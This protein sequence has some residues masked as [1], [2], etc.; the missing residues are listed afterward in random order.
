MEDFN[1]KQILAYK[2]RALIVVLIFLIFFGNWVPFRGALLGLL[3]Y[4][5]WTLADDADTRHQAPADGEQLSPLFVCLFRVS[6]MI[7]KADGHVEKSE[8]QAVEDLITQLEFNSSMRDAAIAQFKAGRD[9]PASVETEAKALASHLNG[10]TETADLSI[11][12]L[13]HVALADFHICENEEKILRDVCMAVYNDASGLNKFLDEARADDPYKVLGLT[14][15]TTDEQVHKAYRQKAKQ[16]HPDVISSQKLPDEMKAF[17]ELHMR[18]L[19]EAKDK[20]LSV[21]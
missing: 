20:L 16:Y 18:K 8:I 1:V 17:A 21:I 19:N 10:D 7:A 5:V 2:W 14:K 15:P 6:G 4:F 9:S 13:C 11:Q 3:L 12:F